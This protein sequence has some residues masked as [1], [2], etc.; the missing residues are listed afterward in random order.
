MELVFEAVRAVREIRNRNTISPRTPLSVVLSAKDEPTAALLRAGADIVRS[1]ANAE[2]VSVGIALPKP[3]FAGTVAGPAFAVYVPLE[4]KIDRKA[5]E[6]R[7]R[8]ELEKARA[9]AA[10][11]EK[12][13]ANEEFRKRKP[14]LAET[15]RENLE[16]ARARIAELEAH[17]KELAE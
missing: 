16:A 9:Q 12:Q 10:Q 1:Q 8:R 6:E 14:E 11:S 7:T 13:L 17:L 4:G 3:R 5:E 2:E 15:V